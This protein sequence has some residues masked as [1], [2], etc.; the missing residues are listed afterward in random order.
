VT[1]E[2]RWPDTGA[3]LRDALTARDVIGALY[4]PA[5]LRLDNRVPA[6]AA[7]WMIICAQLTTNN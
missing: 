3:R 7:T 6:T 2:F 4:A 1:D 5:S